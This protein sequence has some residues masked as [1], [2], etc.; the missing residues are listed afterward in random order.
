MSTSPHSLI[1]AL[2]TT[3]MLEIDGLHAWQFS[4]DNELLAQV[5][6]GSANADSQNRPLLQIECIDGRER[7]HWQ[8]SL[9]AVSAA[10]FDA[11]S[12]TW[13]L[14][15]QDAEHQ[16]KCFAAISADNSD[17]PDDA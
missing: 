10:R 9:A 13:H 6:A 5:S 17:E 11:A 8:F 1:E 16:L 2:V 12:D 15:G 4:V 7:R 3:D 14:A